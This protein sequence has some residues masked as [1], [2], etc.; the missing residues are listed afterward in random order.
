[1]AHLKKTFLNLR[2]LK[3]LSAEDPLEDKN[4]KDVV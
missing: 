1:M 4:E 3:K 2:H